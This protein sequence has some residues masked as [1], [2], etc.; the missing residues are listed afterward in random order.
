[1]PA[2]SLNPDQRF[3]RLKFLHYTEP[4]KHST[5][6]YRKMGLFR[7]DCG[8][9]VIV[10]IAKVKFGHTQSCG[11]LRLDRLRQKIQTH[12]H[13][14]GRVLSGTFK[15][16]SNMMSRCT[17][18]KVEAYKR[19]GGA[20][21]KVCDGLKPF[22]GFLRV[23]GVRPLELEIDRWPNKRGH[24]SCGSCEECQ[25][26]Q[27]PMNVRWATIV[28]QARNRTNNHI[29]TVNG[30][31]GCLSELAEKFNLPHGRVHRR[32]ALGWSIDRVFLTP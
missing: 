8:N 22:N 6:Y 18:E 21:I 10:D 20:G 3:G 28:E 30:I 19:Y 23:L 2:P 25:K 27:W 5:G 26:N 16:W 15:S 12:G 24:Y 32:I 31:T 9:T 1:M 7:C 13:T 14:K 11:C 17:N 29:V 4:R